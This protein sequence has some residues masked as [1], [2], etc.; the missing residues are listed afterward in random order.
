MNHSATQDHSSREI[1]NMLAYRWDITAA[2]ALVEGREP[3][4][5]IS[6]ADAA[7]WLPLIVINQAH[8]AVAD[9]SKPLLVAP[10]HDPK[11][12]AQPF[13]GYLTIDGWHRI[14]RATYECVET[15]PAHLLTTEEERQIRLEGGRAH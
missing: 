4:A 9:L 12:A 3:N 8:A 15:L 14:Y 6:V 10:I 5:V 13:A 7:M 1:F 2:L 11:K